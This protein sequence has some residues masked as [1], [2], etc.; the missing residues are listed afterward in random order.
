MSQFKAWQNEYLNIKGIPTTT[1][2]TPSSSVRDFLRFSQ[3]HQIK[4]GPNVLDIGSG[5]GRNAIY[6]ANLGFNVTA[7]DFIDAALNQLSEK[8]K[9]LG[10]DNIK[11]M[12]VDI[13]QLLPF[14]NNQFGW[15]IDI[16]TTISL[17][18]EELRKFERELRRVIKPGGLFLTYVHSQS[19]EY[20]RER[21]DKDGFYTI[22]ES[23]LTERA[24]SKNKLLEVYSSWQLLAL[25]EK[26]FKDHF[27]SKIYRRSLW[28]AVFKKK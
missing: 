6:L 16:V 2:N 11:V 8:V 1:R 24:F 17:D 9:R 18:D 13:S 23:G 4:L 10:L 28:W 25:R 3:E 26:T 5:P 7:I 14:E 19:D 15:A 22:P 21:V 20:L 27:Y 12:K